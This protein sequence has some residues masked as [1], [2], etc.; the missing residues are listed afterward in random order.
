MRFL[1]FSALFRS[2]TLSCALFAPKRK[3]R[4]WARNPTVDNA[5]LVLLGSIV[6]KRRKRAVFAV[7]GCFFRFW[8]QDSA[9]SPQNAKIAKVQEIEKFPFTKRYYSSP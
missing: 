4:A 6:A 3:N 1:R 8:A 2:K 9:F 7:L 5:F